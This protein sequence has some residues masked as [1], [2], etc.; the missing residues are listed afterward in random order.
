MLTPT[1]LPI[2]LLRSC[3]PSTIADPHLV[4]SLG[5][6]TH[7]RCIRGY[8]TRASKEA[9]WM[10][11]GGNV[12]RYDCFIGRGWW[13]SVVVPGTM[14][15]GFMGPVALYRGTPHLVPLQQMLWSFIRVLPFYSQPLTQP[16]ASLPGNKGEQTMGPTIPSTWMGGTRQASR[17][18]VPVP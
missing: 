5:A 17:Q 6:P 18:G 14:F 12:G 9:D 7:N 8:V 2:V 3:Q 1:L 10:C 11:S 15:K 16:V 4:S 13:T